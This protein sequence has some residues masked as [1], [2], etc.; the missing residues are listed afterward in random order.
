MKHFATH[1]FW[2]RYRQLPAEIQELADRNFVLLQQNPQ[3]P[4]LRLKKIG[5]YWSARV[6]LHYRVLAKER[7][8]GLV[9]FWIGHHN[10]YDQLLRG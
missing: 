5:V 2:A 4:S 8:E 10:V 9:W 7:T 1:D 6:G 3:H